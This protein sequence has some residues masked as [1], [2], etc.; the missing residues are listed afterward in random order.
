MRD[1]RVRRMLRWEEVLVEPT[2]GPVDERP[3]ARDRLGLEGRFPSKYLSLTRLKGD[4]T[5]V[6]TPVWFVIEKDRR[7]IHTDPQSGKAKGIRR[8]PSKKAPSWP[9]PAASL[10]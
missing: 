7:L 1:G 10:R 4:G 2:T 6:A 9:Y 5:G 3:A 8:N